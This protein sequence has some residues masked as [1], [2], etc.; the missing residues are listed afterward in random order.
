MLK[1]R[2]GNLNQRFVAPFRAQIIATIILENHVKNLSE[3]YALVIAIIIAP[4]LVNHSR[5]S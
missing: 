4:L 3:S 1:I 5:E 2:R